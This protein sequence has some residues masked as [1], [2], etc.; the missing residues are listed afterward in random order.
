MQKEQE[1]ADAPW[2]MYV[3]LDRMADALPPSYRSPAKVAYLGTLKLD[4][5][6]KLS[7]ARFSSPDDIY[8]LADVQ[9][10]VG[11]TATNFARA[12]RGSFARV[13]VIAAIGD[14]PISGI[15]ESQLRAECDEAQLLRCEGVAS[16]VVLNVRAPSG[17]GGSRRLL[18]SSRVSPHMMLTA[19]HVAACRKTITASNVLVADGYSL[20]HSTSREALETAFGIARQN[21]VGSVFDLVP[22]SLP[23][24]MPAA[25]VIPVLRAADIVIAE[26]RTVAGL[27][28]NRWP[29]TAANEEELVSR[30][31]TAAMSLAGNATWILRYGFENMED[32]LILREGRVL[33]VYQTGYRETSQKASF[34]DAQLVHELRT[35]L[36]DGA[37]QMRIPR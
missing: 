13:S 2:L 28:E 1:C 7:D 3:T 37:G 18:V 35:M 14:D 23:G 25:D 21:G 31:R 30:A 19:S 16:A 4:V 11:G 24:S 12:A 22:H 32:T 20:Q 10:R 8:E 36:L 9:I 26:A 29:L 15:L 34:G 17:Q 5:L 6:S 27:S 33:D